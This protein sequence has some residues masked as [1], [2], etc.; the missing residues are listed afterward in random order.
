MGDRAPVF[1]DRRWDDLTKEFNFQTR[2]TEIFLPIALYNTYLGTYRRIDEMQRKTQEVID[3]G[4][5]H[6]VMEEGRRD[7]FRLPPDEYL[8]KEL[9]DLRQSLDG[10]DPY[11]V[12]PRGQG[13][14]RLSAEQVSGFFRVFSGARDVVERV[15]DVF[16]N[17][18]YLKLFTHLRHVQKTPYAGPHSLGELFCAA[19]SLNIVTD[20]QYSFYTKTLDERYEK[21]EKKVQAALQDSRLVIDASTQAVR[22]LQN[23]PAP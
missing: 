7:R 6:L 14:V 10:F 1:F 12:T 16:H 23:D 13:M 17:S 15:S 18:D 21:L 19:W 9:D 11:R 5:H 8:K 22:L 2:V 4:E 20:R 3:D